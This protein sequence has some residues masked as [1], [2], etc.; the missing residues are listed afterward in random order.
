MRPDY[1]KAIVDT[2]VHYGWTEI[3]F[4]YDSHDGKLILPLYWSSSIASKY[5]NNFLM[6]IVN[7]VRIDFV[8]HSW[9]VSTSYIVYE[10]Y[11]HLS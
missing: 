4:M 9:L 2:I 5:L 7:L 6:N 1:H 10:Y 3:I 8:Q 11:K